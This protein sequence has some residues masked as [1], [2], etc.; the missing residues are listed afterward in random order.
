MSKPADLD[1]RIVGVLDG[2]RAAARALLTASA[3]ARDAALQAIATALETESARILAANEQDIEAGRASAMSEG[4]LDRL[5]LTERRVSSLAA[6]VREIIALPD[7]VGETVRG[8]TLPN[9]I[10]IEQVRVPLGVVGVIYEARPNVTV[11]LACL[12]LKS[13]NAVV[14]RGGS[15]AEHTNEVLV[16]VIRSAV[17]ST[18]LPADVVA[19]VDRYGREGARSLMRARGW[20]DVLVPRGSAGLIAS[21]VEE[22]LVPV[23]ETGAGVVHLFLDESAPQDWA[24]EITHNAKVHRP[25]VCN[26]LET[27]LVHE[28]SAQR[29]VPPVLGRLAESGVRIHA[30]ERTRALFPDALPVTEDDFATE[31][32]SLDLSVAVVSSLDDAMAHI[33]R[34]STKHT[35][36]IVTNDLGNAERFLNE[37]D[38]AAVLVNASTRFTDGG[39]FGFGA[40]VG[41]ST[42]KLHARGPMG[43]RELT[44]TKWLV[45]GSGQVRE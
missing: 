24:V 16:S 36:A 15:A 39:Q 9:G 11:D 30:D 14:L 32:L 10:R 2:S 40:E 18:G 41:I 27:L 25:S 22:S 19:T 38:A 12:A 3:A 4:L 33:R 8:S 29:L 44:S 35:E 5:T 23:I 6:A 1:P 45:R 13:G 42:Q 20:V 37:V 31:H 21:V 34:Y 28:N 7:P 43:L 26:A 17:A